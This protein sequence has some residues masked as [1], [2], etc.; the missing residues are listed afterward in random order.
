LGEAGL[1][2]STAQ[3]RHPKTSIGKI[4]HAQLR[5]RFEKGEYDA[6]LKQI[7]IETGNANTI[8]DWF[9][10]RV[11]QRAE[12]KATTLLR[13]PRLV[14]SD[15]AGVGARCCDDSAIRVEPGT[16][17]QRV[18]PKH[19]GSIRLNANITPACSSL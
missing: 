18:T 14:F 17:F 3:G 2:D 10:Q 5:Q 7:D 16:S 6:L 12:H 19:Y 13:G 1:F 11:W 9:Y 4:Q 15:P 8:P